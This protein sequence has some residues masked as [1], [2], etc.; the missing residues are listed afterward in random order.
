MQK[1]LI[2]RL[3]VFLARSDASFQ[4]KKQMPKKKSTNV[5]KLST[6]SLKKYLSR[7]APF[8]GLL[9]FYDLSRT[10]KKPAAGRKIL[11]KIKVVPFIKRPAAG[12]I[13]FH[14]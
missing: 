1:M 2:F 12:R 10:G 13:F 9:I 11:V 6:S 5:Q 3:L 8:L 7:T 14:T 4:A